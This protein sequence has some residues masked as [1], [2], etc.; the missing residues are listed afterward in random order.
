[1]MTMVLGTNTL[2]T[3]VR[4]VLTPQ[5]C[6]FAACEHVPHQILRIPCRCVARHALQMDPQPHGT[7]ENLRDHIRAMK[8][9]AV[10]YAQCAGNGA[11]QHV[12]KAHLTLSSGGVLLHLHESRSCGVIPPLAER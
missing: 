2:L 5:V 9:Q 10:P 4:Q 12:Q 6:A 11:E 8:R 1:M 3:Q 7:R